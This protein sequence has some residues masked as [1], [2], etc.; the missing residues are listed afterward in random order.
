MASGEKAT[1][2][3]IFGGRSVEHE[4]SIITGH[5]VLE[6]LD[7]SRWE[8]VPIYLSAEN[9]W[10]VGD[11]RLSLDFFRQDPLP[12]D[13]LYRVDPI[14]DPGSC[15][16]KLRYRR[17]GLWGSREKVLQIILPAVHGTYGEDGSLQGLLEMANVPYVGSSVAGSALGMDKLLTKRILSSLRIPILPWGEVDRW[18][19]ERDWEKVISDWERNWGYPLMVKPA[20][21]GSS[22]GVSRVES[23]ESLKRAVDLCLRWGE[24]ALVE[25]WLEQAREVNCA[26]LDGDPPIASLVEEPIRES[27]LLT[28]EEKYLRG[29]KGKSA[30]SPLSGGM[31]SLARHIPAE[32]DPEMTQRIQ[33]LAKEAFL[34]MR[35][36]GVVRVDFLLSVQGELYLNEVNTI[37]GSFAYYLWE[38]MGK[39]FRE[40]LD[41]L[42]ERAREVHR[43]K[44]RISYLLDTRILK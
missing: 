38:P 39:S 29:K 1:V 27:V 4:I 13:K 9:L 22:I 12:L 44:N 28:F 16:L 10:F 33:E 25:P 11:G 20:A 26:V 8:P 30:D 40:L 41:Y 35:L 32:L 2:G 18:T 5:Q 31:A 43:R 3:V 7:R 21:L 23:Q 15:S 37:P 34:G 42:L 19:W 24:W 14:P 36:G 6:A 17:G